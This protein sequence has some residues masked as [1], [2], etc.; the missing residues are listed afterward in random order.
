MQSI[1]G[2]RSLSPRSH[3]RS[4]DSFPYRLPAT[5]PHSLERVARNR[6]FHVPIIA[7]SNVPEPIRLAPV[8]SPAALVTTCF[9]W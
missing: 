6:V 2:C 1:T 4:L 3:A 5:A 9:L 7:D 8:F